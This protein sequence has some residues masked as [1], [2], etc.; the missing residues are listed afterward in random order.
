MHT[1]DR[2]AA[3]LRELG[4]TAMADKAARAWYDD[5]LSPLDSPIT[6]L[7]DDLAVAAAKN[8]EHAEPIVALRSKAMH[9]E[10]DAT[11]EESDAWAASDEGQEAFRLLMK[12]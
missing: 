3:A 10:F 4:L 12:K 11:K 9:G 2:L 8:P 1:K 7:V 6:T 5:Y